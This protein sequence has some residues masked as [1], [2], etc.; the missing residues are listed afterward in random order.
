MLK[1]SNPKFGLEA[2]VGRMRTGARRLDVGTSVYREAASGQLDSHP[3]QLGDLA[4]IGPESIVLQP[5]FS[6]RSDNHYQVN[7]LLK[8]HDRAFIQNAYRAIL[9]RGPDATGFTNFIES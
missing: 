7:D 4:S 3:D 2:I 5:P 6:P 8:Y 9:K 1:K